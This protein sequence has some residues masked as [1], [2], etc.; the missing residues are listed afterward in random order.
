M[1]DRRRPLGFLAILAG[2]VALTTLPQAGSA[3]ENQPAARPVSGPA[4]VKYAQAGGG[5]S[6]AAAGSEEFAPAGAATCLRCHD[7]RPVNFILHTPHAQTADPRT[8]FA[9][10]DCETCH[11]ASP[12]HVRESTLTESG[13]PVAIRF[14]RDAPTPVDQQNG[15]CLG[16]HESGVRINWQGSQHAFADIP[17]AA[18]HD[19]HTLD[20]P[21]QSKATQ[22]QVCFTCHTAQRAQSFRFSH[23]PMREGKVVCSECHAP[24]GSFGPHLLREAR[25][26][27]T[28]Y[29]CHQDKRGP[30]L[31]EHPPVREDCTN[32]H[33]PHGSTQPRLLKA[34]TPFLCQECHME[35]FHP[36]SLY[37]GA[38]VPPRG[39]QDRLLLKGCLNCHSQVHGSNHPSGVRFM[40]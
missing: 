28:C 18:C 35:A 2:V 8:P 24:H 9:V 13:A 19:I 3:A 4:G 27:D 38:G 33:T 22:A 17:C 11:G 36:S 21:V 16:C 20:D 10:H 14:G 32:C 34:R 39:I 29:D 37:S 1:G 26:N 25:V 31:W 15:V 23:H 7:Q 30:F 40:R 12:E 6:G 5:E